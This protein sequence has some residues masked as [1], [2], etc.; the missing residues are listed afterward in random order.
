MK[1]RVQ[2]CALDWRVLTCGGNA[3][4]E[5]EDGPRTTVVPGWAF[6]GV[7]EDIAENVTR[8]HPGHEVAGVIPQNYMQSCACAEYVQAFEGWLVR[9]PAQL[10]GARVAA[11]IS[12]GQLAYRAVY[13][14]MKPVKGQGIALVFAALT[15]CGSLAVQLL[16][17]LDIYVILVAVAEDEASKLRSMLGKRCCLD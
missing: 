12:S 16:L 11:S 15:G 6:V 9:K 5:T 2:H 17:K 1:V 13:D 7:V 3:S 4:E 10:D 8:F 14:K